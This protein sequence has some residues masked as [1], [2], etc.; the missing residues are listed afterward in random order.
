M[1][2]LVNDL[3]VHAGDVVRLTREEVAGAGAAAGGMGVVV[4]KVAG[5]ADGAGA[6]PEAAPAKACSN[7]S[8]HRYV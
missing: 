3:D 5:G 7:G 8:A 6:G 4:E 1:V 2:P